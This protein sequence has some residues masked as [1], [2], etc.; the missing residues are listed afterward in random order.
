MLSRLGITKEQ[1]IIGGAYVVFM[2]V[3]YFIGIKKAPLTSHFLA[4]VVLTGAFY[5]LVRLVKMMLGK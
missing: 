5:A 1:V 3:F 4:A 2:L